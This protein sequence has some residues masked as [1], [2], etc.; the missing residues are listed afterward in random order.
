MERN[1]IILFL[2]LFPL[3]FYI[4]VKLSIFAYYKARQQYKEM[5]NREKEQE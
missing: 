3:W 5:E 4:L 2:I 1:D